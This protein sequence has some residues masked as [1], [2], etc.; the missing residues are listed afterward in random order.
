VRPQLL[1]GDRE[2]GLKRLGFVPDLPVVYVTGGARG[3]SPI[4]QRIE[5]ILPELLTRAQVI[6]QTGPIS[7]NE[8]A[9]RLAE[10]R[11]Q[12][13]SELRRR[14]FLTQFLGEEL[15]DIYAAADLTIGRSGAGTVAELAYAGIPAILIPLPGTGGDEQSVNARILADVKAAV[16][17][18][19][20]EA[21][22][23]RLLAEVDSLLANKQRRE[24]MARAALTVARP[25]AASRMADIVVELSARQGPNRLSG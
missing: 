21:T 20:V 3:A 10:L 8:D 14:Y 9:R 19:Q 7:A 17:L 18:P 22:P 5:A 13:P 4:N 24:Q 1:E 2:R 6:H 23:G 12:L 25:D 16:L 11:A 15:P